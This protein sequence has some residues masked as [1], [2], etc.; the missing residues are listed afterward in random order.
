MAKPEGRHEINNVGARQ[1]LAQ[2]KK[3]AE[4]DICKPVLPLNN[5]APGKRKNSA[6]SRNA[7]KE[8]TSKQ[9][10]M[11]EPRARRFR[12]SPTF[13]SL[14]RSIQEIEAIDKRVSFRLDQQ[15]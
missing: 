13:A 1:K 9:L 6:E 5:D 3:I 7:R 2:R 8:K 15:P 4:L 10:A 14:G 12:L 11:A